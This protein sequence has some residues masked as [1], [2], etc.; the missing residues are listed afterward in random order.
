[1]EQAEALASGAAEP[2]V[3]K[4]L[5]NVG[6]VDDAVDVDILWDPI[7]FRTIR[8][9]DAE[10]VVEVDRAAE[11]HISWAIQTTIAIREQLD[12]FDAGQTTAA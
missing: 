1:M 8:R 10:D 3:G 5:K 11:I 2:P 12:F 9:Q 4:S 6:E 7:A